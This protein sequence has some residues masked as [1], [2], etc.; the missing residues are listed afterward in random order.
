[1]PWLA[2]A[3]AAVIVLIRYSNPAFALLPGIAFV[4]LFLLFRDPLRKVPSVALGV[5]S[6]VDGT[7]TALGPIET[8]ETGA[9]AL[10]IEIEV[11][12]FGTYTARA[13]VEGTIKEMGKKALWL[14]TD[15]GQDVVLKFSE[16]RFGLVPKSFA[17]YGERL[18]QGQRCAY[19]RLTRF[20]EVQIPVDGKILVEIGQKVMAGTD[21]IANVHKP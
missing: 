2:L 20:A 1:L 13:P 5:F 4:L 3:L 17:R 6:P 9:E 10:R 19:L 14:Q 18:G 15:E 12:S 11:D 21:V 7:V 8:S 16:Y